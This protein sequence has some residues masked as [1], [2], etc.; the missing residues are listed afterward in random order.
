MHY[1]RSRTLKQ[2]FLFLFL[3]GGISPVLSQKNVL[4]LVQ[5][6]RE[7]P[8]DLERAN[9]MGL[10]I[11]HITETEIFAAVTAKQV[12]VLQQAKFS[13]KIL[14]QAAGGERYYLCTAR[15]QKM[16]TR[17][18]IPGKVLWV[19]NR[20]AVLKMDARHLDQRVYD[21]C[22]LTEMRQVPVNVRQEVS[23]C[24]NSGTVSLDS[25]IQRAVDAV[26]ADSIH[27]TVQM[28]Q[29]F[30]TRFLFAPNHDSVAIW[31]RDEFLRHGMTNVVL[32][33]FRIA[34]TWAGVYHDTWQKNV[35]ATFPGSKSPSVV[36]VT[37]GHHD[38]YSS[39]N[40]IVTAPG[41]DDNASG[42]AA[43]L[44]LARV[45]KQTGYVPEVT[46]KF[47]TFAAEELGL[48]GGYDFAAKASSTG[49]KIK[50]MINHDMIS[51]ASPSGVA[52]NYYTGFLQNAQTARD[53]TTHFTT[54]NTSLGG[55]NSAGSDSYPFWIYGYPA[56]YFEEGDFS[57]VYH[58]P[59]DV[60]GNTSSSFCAEVV[61]GSCATLIQA[62]R[63]PSPPQNLYL[64]DRGDGSHLLAAWTPSWESDVVSYTVHIGTS[65][66]VSSRTLTTTQTHAEIDGLTDG[67]LYSIGVSCVDVDGHESPITERMQ[68][69]LS[70]PRVPT[71]F[72]AIPFPEKISLSWTRNLEIDLMGYNIYRSTNP[73][74]KGS[75]LNTKEI[76]DTLY[77]DSTAQKGIYS[78]YSI[79]AVD[80]GAAESEASAIIRSRMVS[81]DQGICI[82]DETTDGDGT[83]M[84][85]SDAQVDAFYQYV[86]SDFQTSTYDVAAEGSISLA[87]I[88]A[89]S[90]LLWHGND[91]SDIATLGQKKD[92]LIQYL[93]YGGR[94]V[95]TSYLPSRAL[96]GNTSISADFLPGNILY[97]YFGI[98]KAEN[99]FLSRFRSAIANVPGYPSI[100]VD[101]TKT[102]AS[103]EYHLMSVESISA[104]P[105]ATDIYSYA[106]MYDTSTIYGKML[107]KPVGVENLTPLYKVVTLSFPLYY[108]NPEQA[109]NL[110]RH[111]FIDR[112]GIPTEVKNF[113]ANIP[114]AYSLSQNYPNPFN[115]N[116]V[117]SYQLPVMSHISLKVYDLLGREVATLVNEVKP[118]GIFRHLWNASTL[119]SGV[120]FYQLQAGSYREVKKAL[121]LK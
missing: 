56:V 17:G 14:D 40:P 50:L 72:Q 101:S 9:R 106:S 32:D 46:I 61:K 105:G 54:L 8:N 112:F 94:L 41:A 75:K 49:M 86:L 114:S 3:I 119:P 97:D 28:L 99:R 77:V 34:G 45:L 98:A 117:I 62:D 102:L 53:L 116:T 38:S 16:L 95:L 121:L 10:M 92:Q 76:V 68:S 58:T 96:D 24:L 44:E 63:V 100:D 7:S 69:S 11:Y 110:I 74:E 37:G 120:Y 108:M 118:A 104:A 22:K 84:N 30:R 111:V 82:V 66:G 1:F 89:Y 67:T 15:S 59:N 55:L 47:A 107:G 23:T 4:S 21:S 93:N 83:L 71:A 19:D 57:P 109:K 35:V 87:D 80:S 42:T 70:T 33:S 36:I 29:N 91:I 103:Y 18:D 31:I 26:S 73:A 81:M 90:T 39:G 20:S 43:V 85:P 88:G 5:I 6:H 12:P 65:P 113:H 13:F 48:Y 115:P 51:N 2:F 27:A 79:C 64:S 52:I 78:Y 60:I 25:I